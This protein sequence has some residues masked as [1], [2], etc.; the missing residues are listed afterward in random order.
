MI[1]Q[2][3]WQRYGG[4]EVS[5]KGDKRFSAFC[6]RLPDGRSIEQHYQCDVKGYCPGGT[7]WKLGKG[8]APRKDITEE[9]LY[10]EYLNL[11]KQWAK[12]NTVLLQE[13]TQNA[14]PFNGML[15]DMF[16]ATPINQARALSDILNTTSQDS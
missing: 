7:D 3:T 8:K 14:A 4:Y 13:L 12:T 15:S 2:Y 9:A 11:W 6:A 16:A 10:K 1:T 5:T